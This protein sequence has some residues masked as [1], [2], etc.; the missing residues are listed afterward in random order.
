MDLNVLAIGRKMPGWIAQGW[1]EYARRMPSHL[2]LNLIELDVAQ[3]GSAAEISSAEAAAL[4][5]RMPQPAS[6]VAL[7]GRG[8]QW[9]TEQL[10]AQLEN[11]QMNGQAVNFLIGGANGLDDSIRMQA[12]QCWSLGALTLPHMLVRV[13]LAEQL[14]RAWTVTAGHPYHRA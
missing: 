5:K 11:W 4:Q 10:A 2:K 9:S 6:T 7:D 1:Q 14:Y 13:V 8:R 3:A 12:N